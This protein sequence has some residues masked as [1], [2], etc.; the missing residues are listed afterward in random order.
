[1][2]ESATEVA[3]EYRLLDESGRRRLAEGFPRLS[4]AMKSVMAEE[5]RDH[6]RDSVELRRE[7]LA[8]KVNALREEG[9]HVPTWMLDEARLARVR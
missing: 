1:M 2:S 6:L 7:F 4:A 9:S 5:D 3:T 8:R